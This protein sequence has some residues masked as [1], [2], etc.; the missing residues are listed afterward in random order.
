MIDN[1]SD[2]Y[3]ILDLEPGATMAEVKSSYRELV[4]VWHP[5]RFPND[6]KFQKR[7]ADK[8]KQINSAYE[9]ISKGGVTQPHRSPPAAEAN[10]P[11]AE[12]RTPQ[13][14]KKAPQV[15]KTAHSTGTAS[16]RNG[17]QQEFPP[18]SPYS[19]RKPTSPSKENQGIR[20]L[21]I[22]AVIV[23]FIV[24]MA[25]LSD[26]HSQRQSKD[27]SPPS[28]TFQPESPRAIAN[29]VNPSRQ[30]PTNADFQ[31][32]QPNISP[33][34]DKRIPDYA[35]VPM[36]NVASKLPTAI[37][38]RAQAPTANSSQSVHS[39]G[40]FTI[41][42]DKDEVLSVQGTPSQ[43]N[44]NEFSYAYSSVRFRDGRVIAWNDI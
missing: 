23:I 10:A 36:R 40:F 25:V 6:P 17:T 13:A 35:L 27:P 33:M 5:D 14:E 2:C 16:S 44:D 30:V 24:V 4:K 39:N 43:M 32:A 20:F 12:N 15:E 8:L 31:T 11:Q 42:S 21:Q 34:Q 22:V 1:L 37:S 26:D 38:A 7:G 3:R 41:G 9:R 19:S 18:Q 29:T 28:T